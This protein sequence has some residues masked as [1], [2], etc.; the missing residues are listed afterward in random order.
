MARRRAPD[1]WDREWPPTS[2]NAR[3]NEG[4]GEEISCTICGHWFKREDLDACVYCSRI[5]CPRC[6]WWWDMDREIGLCR[7]CFREGIDAV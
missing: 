6:F 3:S 4:V 2:V 7:I 1:D 5:T